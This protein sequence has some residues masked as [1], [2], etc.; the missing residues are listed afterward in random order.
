MDTLSRTALS[1]MDGAA[2]LLAGLGAV[3][4]AVSLLGATEG[5][6]PLYVGTVLLLAGIGLYLWAGR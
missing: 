4:A 5:R 2:L 1:G 3:A 6:L